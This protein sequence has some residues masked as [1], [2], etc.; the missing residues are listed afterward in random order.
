[1]A[2]QGVGIV[3]ITHNARHAIEVGDAFA[4]LIRGRVASTFR[5]GERSRAE[6]LD[7]MAGGEKFEGV[8]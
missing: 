5:G 3:F 2:S 1:V 8:D 4:V 7:L 6:M